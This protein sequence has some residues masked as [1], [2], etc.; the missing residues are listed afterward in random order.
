MTATQPAT[1]AIRYAMS[2]P[3]N[4]G[5]FALRQWTVGPPA[6]L[7][8]RLVGFILR[9]DRGEVLRSILGWSF[10]GELYPEPL[11]HEQSLQV[12]TF[13]PA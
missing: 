10:R 13:H 2:T 11:L 5:D 4:P 12:G 7:R 3:E 8:P 1:L 6:S 9:F